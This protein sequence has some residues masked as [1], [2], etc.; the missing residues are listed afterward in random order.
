M[1]A[2]LAM[3]APVLR[4]WTTTLVYETITAPV[5]RR[6]SSSMRAASSSR[7]MV[8]LRPATGSSQHRCADF[9][10]ARLSHDGRLGVLS[11]VDS[12]PPTNDIG[13]W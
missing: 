5:D 9:Q 12:P 2:N 11:A 1:P 4:P 6:R 7:H 3:P 13:S 10:A 8:C